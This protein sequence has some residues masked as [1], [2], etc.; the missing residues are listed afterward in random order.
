[1]KTLLKLFANYRKTCPITKL[2]SGCVSFV[3]DESYIKHAYADRQRDAWVIIPWGTST[4]SC[5]AEST[6]YYWSK[7][8]EYEF[9][10]FHNEINKNTPLKTNIIGQNC[11]IHETAILN[12]EGI[13]YT[14]APGG[15]RIQ[16]KHIGNVKL[17]DN[18]SIF[19]LAT[20]QRGIF[21]STI[22]E[23]GVKID[24]RVNIGH[25]SYIGKNSVVALGAILGG[26]VTLGENC[27]IG[28]GAII[29]NGIN[30]CS[31]VIIGQGSN[32]VS[33][34]TEP[35]IYMGNPAKIFKPYDDKWNF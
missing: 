15:S 7:Y 26:S 25:N 5:S 33:S 24:S 10:L 35:G 6:K 21:G 13:H 19:A 23:E 11:F 4:P 30:I 2:R 20:I 32:V 14:K 3:R 18:V 9:T 17:G 8:P 31:N 22:L 27:M 28:L 29:R 16:M 12:I 1:M 34:I